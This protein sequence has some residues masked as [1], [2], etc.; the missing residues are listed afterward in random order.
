MCLP[1]AGEAVLWD[2]CCLWELV[3]E[4][5]GAS[6]EKHHIFG[7]YEKKPPRNETWEQ[8]ASAPRGCLSSPT[9]TKWSNFPPPGVSLVELYPWIGRHEKGTSMVFF[10]KTHNT[11]LIKRKHQTNSRGGTFHRTADQTLQECQGHAVPG[12]A[13]KL[14]QQRGLRRHKDEM[15]HDVLG[16]T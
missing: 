10:P 2:L 4:N 9:F 15:Q 14:S 13:G 16:G 6:V 11:D 12:K 3:P 8:R 1:S 5:R 7:W